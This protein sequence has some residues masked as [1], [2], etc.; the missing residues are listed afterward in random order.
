MY[1]VFILI[2][3]IYFLNTEAKE[4]SN[5]QNIKLTTMAWKIEFPFTTLSE[6]RHF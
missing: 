6:Y 5:I 2:H 1:R 4:S 3:D